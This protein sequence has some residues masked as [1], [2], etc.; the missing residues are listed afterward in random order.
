MIKRINMLIFYS[1]LC[2][3]WWYINIARYVHN[4]KEI[5]TNCVCA[6]YSFSHG[7]REA[8]ASGFIWHGL[9]QTIVVI[10]QHA[11]CTLKYF[12]QSEFLN[13]STRSW[14]ML[15]TPLK[16]DQPQSRFL[17][18]ANKIL[19]GPVILNVGGKR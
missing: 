13:L 15:S 6:V 7:C 17:I 2:A 18:A 8:K 14:T 16:M 9:T 10:R 1:F 3:N 12:L 5:F 19:K 11:A 4:L